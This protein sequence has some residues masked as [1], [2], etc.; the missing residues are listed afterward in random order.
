MKTLILVAIAV[1]FPIPSRLDIAPTRGPW[2]RPQGRQ[3]CHHYVK[4]SSIWPWNGRMRPNLV[5]RPAIPSRP[6]GKPAIRNVTLADPRAI[7]HVPGRSRD[8]TTVKSRSSV[9]NAG[10]SSVRPSPADAIATIARCACSA[11][12]S[13]EIVLVIEQAR[14]EP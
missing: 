2:P 7:G 10:R 5:T 13:M 4:M 11:A 3:P 14:A 12:T 6:T 8:A 9:A 1:V